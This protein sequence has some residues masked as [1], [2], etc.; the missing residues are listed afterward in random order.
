MARVRVSRNEREGREEEW[1]SRGAKIA[2]MKRGDILVSELTNP[3]NKIT[4]HAEMEI[5]QRTRIKSGNGRCA[6]RTSGAV[7]APTR[8]RGH[9]EVAGFPRVPQSRVRLNA[10]GCHHALVNF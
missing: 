10:G 5:N 9:I 6:Q 1:G 2:K 4:F 8:A 3:K 7:Q